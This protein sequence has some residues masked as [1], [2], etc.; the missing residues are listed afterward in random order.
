MCD[1]YAEIAALSDFLS[2]YIKN[3]NSD[4]ISINLFWSFL[5]YV[6]DMDKS[7]TGF[8]FG[9]IDYLLATSFGY[10][11]MVLCSLQNIT[12]LEMDN[13]RKLGIVEEK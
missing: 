2:A 5:I 6:N 11:E 12:N 10:N 13:L 1:H 7:G 9:Y 4:N 8:N 3:L